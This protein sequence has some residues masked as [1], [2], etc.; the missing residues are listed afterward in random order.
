MDGAD[1]DGIHAGIGQNPT[2][3]SSRQRPCPMRRCQ[4][5]NHA[6]KHGVT[7]GATDIG[8]GR[9]EFQMSR[10]SSCVALVLFWSL[11]LHARETSAN[12]QSALPW[13]QLDALS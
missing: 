9:V 6:C 1:T 7:R 13:V 3:Q 11:P 8:G 12:E 5:Q 2:R 4:Q 10:M